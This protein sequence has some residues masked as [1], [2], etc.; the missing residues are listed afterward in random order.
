MGIVSGIGNQEFA[1]DRAITR[2]EMAAMLRMFITVMEVEL[3]VLDAEE[4]TPFVDRDSISAWALHS[5]EFIQ[6]A[7]I[8]SGR[9]GGYF[10]PQATATRAEVATIFARFLEILIDAEQ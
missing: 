9:P 7:G 2:Q 3:P 6:A 10:D 4:I 8:I 5:V 1:P